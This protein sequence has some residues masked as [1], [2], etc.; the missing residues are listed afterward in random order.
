LAVYPVAYETGNLKPIISLGGNVSREGQGRVFSSAI[1]S[2]FGGVVLAPSNPKRISALIQ[3]LDDIA[4]PGQIITVY[5]G[6]LGTA[7]IVLSAYG[8][9][10]IDINFPW[11]GEI[12][13][14][15]I[16]NNPLVMIWEI[17]LI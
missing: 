6:G 11:T 4:V 2:A 8:T 7:P 17:S 15:S 14:A 10:Q 3:N 12:D 16:S 9:L 13:V 1:V 5:L